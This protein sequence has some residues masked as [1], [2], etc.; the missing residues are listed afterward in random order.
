MKL[1][2]PKLHIKNVLEIKHSFLVRN[3]VRGII[4]DLDNTLSTHG[5]PEAENGISGW[6]EEM[7]RLGV[8][9]VLLSNNKKSRVEPF[10][11][12]HKLAYI[13][14]A[15][16]PL[17]FGI[18]RALKIMKL[19]KE[20]VIMAGDQIFTD[21]IGGNLCGVKTVLVEPFQA[22]DYAF[23]RLKRFAEKII[24]GREDLK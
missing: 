13:S 24:F 15:C 16:K 20:Q 7:K 19:P 9:L 1:F 12:K 6:L 23:F 21:V 14:F 18:K 22:E 17:G 3:H 5:S 10:A 2:K 8:R 4:L 11:A